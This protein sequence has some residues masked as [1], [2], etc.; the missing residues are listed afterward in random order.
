[1]F[2]SIALRIAR[3]GLTC[4]VYH[5]PLESL[6]AAPPAFRVGHAHRPVRRRRYASPPTSLLERAFLRARTVLAESAYATSAHS[7]LLA[8][9][10]LTWG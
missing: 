2:A 5:R 6:T 1:M 3:T 9:T 8:D 7:R 10:T 4:S